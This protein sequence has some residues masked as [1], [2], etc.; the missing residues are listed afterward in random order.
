MQTNTTLTFF[1]KQ[2]QVGISSGKNIDDTQAKT[3]KISDINGRC[4][5]T[6]VSRITMIQIYFFLFGGGEGKGETDKS[7]F[8][9][10]EN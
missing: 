10:K 8:L 2:F 1:G 4:Q 3:I 9:L 5:I 6:V 7:F